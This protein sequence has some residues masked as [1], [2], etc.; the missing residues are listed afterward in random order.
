MSY[1]DIFKILI[2][3]FLG[4]LIGLE[5]EYRTKPAG[6]RTLILICV[7]STLFTIVSYK[8]GGT[9]NPDRIA[10]YVLV[11]I[12]FIGSGSIFKEGLTVTG[13]TT[14]A[15]IWLT[16][17]LG[18]AIGAGEYLLSLA[19][20]VVVFTTLEIFTRFEDLVDRIHSVHLIKISYK[21]DEEIM[22]RMEAQFRTF[23]P[24]MKRVHLKKEGDLLIAH[25][26][27]EGGKIKFDALRNFL[28]TTTEIDGFET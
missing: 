18:M 24:R 8:I 14:A 2:A 5:R 6:L 3:L 22:K 27:V 15:T 21:A 16:A 1:D 4:A 17:G 12:G 26:K 20:V 11:G 10:S 19:I 9:A 28:I 13:L 25:Y 7:G 23:C